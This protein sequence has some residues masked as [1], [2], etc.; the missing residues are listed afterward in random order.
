MSDIFH[1]HPQ[2]KIY[3]R[4]FLDP[5]SGAVVNRDDNYETMFFY[6]ADE[7]LG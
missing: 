1:T 2:C 7:Y 4:N 3:Y 5:K 6:S